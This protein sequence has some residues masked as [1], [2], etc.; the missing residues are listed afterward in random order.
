MRIALENYYFKCGNYDGFNDKYEYETLEEFVNALKK[1]GFVI[2]NEEID[3]YDGNSYTQYYV[4]LNS[5]D[6]FRTIARM[7]H[8]PIHY[9]E[10][11]DDNRWLEI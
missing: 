4:Y 11:D 9:E 2:S 10:I 8:R 3:L 6:E 1:K 7:A 5:F